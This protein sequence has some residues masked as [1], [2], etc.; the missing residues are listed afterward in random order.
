MNKTEEGVVSLTGASTFT[1]T[2][3]HDA[4]TIR[5]NNNASLGAAGNS[6]ILA[7]GVTLSTSAGTAR[8]L[9]HNYTVNGDISLG[10]SAGGTAALT[11]FGTMNLGGGTRTFSQANAA[12]SISAVISNG[13]MIKNSSGILTLSGANTFTGGFQHNEGT[14]RVG[15][16]AAFGAAGS[17]V[18]LADGVTL[19]P[20]SAVARELTYNWDVNGDI[21]LGDAVGT[22]ILT[23]AGTMDLTGGTRAFTVANA[24]SVISADISNGALTKAGAGTLTLS[25]ANTY[26]GVTT[27]N[28][29]KLV[30]TALS[31]GA[32]NYSVEPLATLG[33]LRND[34][35]ASLNVGDLNLNTSTMEFDFNL[36]GFSASGFAN[37]SGNL[38]LTGANII[39]V[40]GFNTAGTNVLL[41]YG[42]RSGD[43]DFALG[44]APPRADASIIDDTL[45]QR[46]VLEV[47]SV[48][49]VR[50]VGDGAGIW[51]VNEVANTVWALQ[52]AA[53]ETYYQENA[54]QGDTVRFDD[55]ATG[56]T[57]VTLAGTVNPFKMTVDNSTKDYTFTGGSITGVADGLTKSGSGKLTIA[58]GANTFTGGTT[59]N[60]GTFL[61]GV[62]TAMGV[63]GG[64]VTVNGGTIASDSATARTL[65][66]AWTLNNDLTLGLGVLDPET[67][68]TGVL[69][70]SG[71]MDLAGGTR[72]ITIAN[73]SD[74]ISAVISNG[75]LVKM[76][77]AH[78]CSVAHSIHTRVGR[79]S[80]KERS[81]SVVQRG[82]AA[83]P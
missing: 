73:A 57:T 28:A 34:V 19:S 48:D 79:G 20:N 83:V 52:N 64:S 45:N 32:G 65:N 12:N 33:I 61:A 47:A 44:I 6:V 56:L 29:G 5:V 3:N 35:V 8:T 7:D 21:T 36:L 55:T 11:L 27:V 18:S 14:V 13:G 54:M 70:L 75:G 2:I 50:W 10:Q 40:R 4:G 38:A 78:W 46:Y 23:M 71:T 15:N 81:P 30:T 59:L 41:G 43:G 66:H 31:T 74:T 80:T 67:E 42:T 17:V 72:T 24:V 60:D 37:S 9:N 39:D 49:S 58:T 16:A 26:S 82:W 53:T 69:T 68:G 62:N 22:G 77:R 76:A 25:G 1:G 51:N 63:A